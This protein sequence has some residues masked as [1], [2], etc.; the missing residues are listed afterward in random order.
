MVVVECSA[1]GT[2]MTLLEQL[3]GLLQCTACIALFDFIVLRPRLR[4]PSARWFAL[5]SS[6]NWAVVITSARDVASVF[7]APLC[8]LAHPMQSWLPAQLTIGGHLYHALAFSMKPNEVFHHLTFSGLGG[9]ITLA[10]PWGPLMSLCL[11]LMSGLPGAIDYALLA[12]VKLG[13]MTRLREKQINTQINMWLRIPGLVFC[14]STAW[15]C[16]AHGTTILPTP[17]LC[18]SIVMC[19]FNGLYYGAQ[20]IGSYHKELALAS[21]EAQKGHAQAGDY[22]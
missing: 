17:V 13:L 8:A 16:L 2:T 1:A 21:R 14:S 22:D 11:C 19:L 9:V 4:D 5:H 18:F 20:V 12:R 6:F 15:C 3:T 10:L 7:S